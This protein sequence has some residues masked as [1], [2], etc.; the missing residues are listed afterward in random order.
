M[1]AHVSCQVFGRRRHLFCLA[2]IMA[3]RQHFP[4]SSR[5]RRDVTHSSAAKSMDTVLTF[6]VGTLF[7]VVVATMTSPRK[8]IM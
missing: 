3:E 8:G 6:E 4:V 2:K 7:S 1:G 5:C